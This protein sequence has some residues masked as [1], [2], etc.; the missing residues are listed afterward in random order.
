MNF[1]A[2]FKRPLALSFVL[3]SSA[4][5]GFSPAWG[6]EPPQE[7]PTHFSTSLPAPQPMTQPL[8]EERNDAA[9][10]DI[11]QTE[12]GNVLSY[13]PVEDSVRFAQTSQ[14]YS[15]I[16]QQILY[17]RMCQ[18]FNS[19]LNDTTPT[20]RLLF[21]AI[22]QDESDLSNKLSKVTDLY[23]PLSRG[24]DV[25]NFEY[26]M[27]EAFSSAPALP[28]DHIQNP[29]VHIKKI[30]PL[31]RIIH[32]FPDHEALLMIRH[33]GKDTTGITRRAHDISYI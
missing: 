11:P 4:A 21:D 32:L 2:D 9:E 27:K 16:S 13:L 18:F 20:L 33:L 14:K 10:P 25:K 30:T 23:S 31:L 26:F 24:V 5:V 28:E 12:L 1:V 6:V 19:S 3:L 7:D 15:A 17:Q 29:V 22:T 8:E